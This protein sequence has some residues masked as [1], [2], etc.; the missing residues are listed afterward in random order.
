MASRFADM[1]RLVT[2]SSIYLIANIINRGGAFLLIPVYTRYM[3]VSDYGALEL[4]YSFSLIVTVLLSAGM[5]HATLRFYYE[6]KDLKSRHEVITTN[7]AVTFSI[8]LI[9]SAILFLWSEQICLLLL[10]SLQYKMALQYCCLL[11]VFNISSEILLAYLR[12]IENSW[13]YVGTSLVK[14]LVQVTLSFYLLV[15]QHMGVNGA[16]AANLASSFVIWAVLVV[17]CGKQ[18]GFRVDLGKTRRILT[19]SFPFLVSSLLGVAATNMDRFVLKHYMSLQDVG[20]YGLGAKFGMILLLVVSEPFYRAYGAYRF[21]IMEND[22]SKE[23]QS[24]VLKFV[25]AV[26]VFAGLGISLF[27]ADLIRLMATDDYASA[28]VIVPFLAAGHIF[29]TA[30]YC[31]QTGILYQKKP[32]FILYI[33]VIIVVASIALNFSLVPRFGALGAALSFMVVKIV[34]CL[35]TNTVS[36]RFYSIKYDFRAM[37]TFFAVGVALYSSFYL[38]DTTDLFQSILLKS[39]MVFLYLVIVA[40]TDPDIKELVVKNIYKLRSAKVTR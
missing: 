22:N 40:G 27:S 37:S 15:Y 29:S 9:G 39:L 30:S 19:Y 18:C 34:E 23:I 28:F 4:V 35:M 16:M 12:A 31:F 33:N 26:A 11:I 24:L 21:S 5:S 10:D 32:R 25:F 1:K 7:F 14:F 2:H 8:G 13:L 17:Y 36:Q 20:I 6:Y 3:P 38:V